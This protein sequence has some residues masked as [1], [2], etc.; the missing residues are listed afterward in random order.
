MATRSSKC[1]ACGTR[2][3]ASSGYCQR[4]KSLRHRGYKLIKDEGLLLDQAGGSWWIWDKRGEVLVSGKPTAAAAVIALAAGDTE[5]QAE[6][7][8]AAQ[9]DA[10]IAEVLQFRPPSRT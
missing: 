2:T 7:K 8:T 10:E 1:H 3:T 4:C 5:N 9:L 6:P